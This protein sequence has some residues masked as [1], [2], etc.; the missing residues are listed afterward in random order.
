MMPNYAG[1]IGN[2]DFSSLSH[3]MDGFNLSG[4]FSGIGD[5]VSGAVSSVKDAFDD[6]MDD[7]TH[8]RKML[9]FMI[10][11]FVHVDEPSQLQTK[12]A[13]GTVNKT[14]DGLVGW[15]S[16]ILKK[17]GGS[18]Q[19]TGP[20]AEGWRSAVKKGLRENGLPT[21]AAYVNAWVRQIQTESGGN[22]KAVQGGYTDINTITG[23]L[24]KGLLQTI[25]ATF[26]ANKFPGHGNIFNG[27]D[28]ILAAIHYAKGRY[29]SSGMLG[30]IGHGHGYENGGLGNKEGLYPLF[31]GN[32]TEMVLP[33]TNV[34]RSMQLIK[35]ALSFM[36]Q[37]FSDGLQMPDALTQTMDL[38]SLG[39]QS[40]AS[41]AQNINGGGINELSSNIVNALLQ[42]LQMANSGSGQ[43]SSQPID[44]HVDV[45]VAGEDF[46]AAAVKGI[47]AVNQKNGRNMLR[48]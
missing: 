14:E 12:L 40:G 39:G 26:N 10:K 2:F 42:G 32:K 24:A 6:V 46:G 9:D 21:S 19:Q 47:N 23:D 18:S 17:F 4:L 35:Q 33:L 15:A 16:K 28:N 36:G 31:E 3:I 44:I 41:N 30:V 13:K 38:S 5:T 7:V 1:G 45:N 22:Q 29:G 48:L 11:K 34:P 37:N 8:P 25:S 27:Y 43:T 20:G